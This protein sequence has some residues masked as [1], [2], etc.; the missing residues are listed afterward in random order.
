MG[1]R[2]AS[3]A[4]QKL[5]TASKLIIQL[6]NRIGLDRQAKVTRV[7][8]TQNWFY[9]FPLHL[10]RFFFLLHFGAPKP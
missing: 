1:V 7:V 8:E 5:R 4:N 3:A 9:E 6:E 2:K 10:A